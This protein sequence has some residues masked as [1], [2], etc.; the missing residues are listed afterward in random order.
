MQRIKTN[1]D[2]VYHELKKSDHKMTAREVSNNTG[3]PFHT[4]CHCL[5]KLCFQWKFIEMEYEKVPD[6]NRH[7]N[8]YFIPS[9]TPAAKRPL[10]VY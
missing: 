8:L 1:L 4:A 7:R 2:I 9:Q 10:R 5:S 3:L 6:C